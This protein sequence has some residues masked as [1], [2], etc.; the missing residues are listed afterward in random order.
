[1]NKSFWDFTILAIFAELERLL[2]FENIKTCDL[3]GC[4]KHKQK[5]FW[6]KRTKK[7]FENQLGSE[8]G[9]NSPHFIIVGSQAEGERHDGLLVERGDHEL[10]RFLHDGAGAR[11]LWVDHGHLDRGYCT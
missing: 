11:R 6:G 1:M 7:G 8:A 2:Y 5:F 9:K 4:E 3:F 10:P